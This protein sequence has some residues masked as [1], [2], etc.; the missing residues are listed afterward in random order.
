PGTV[1]YDDST[2]HL[3]E[4]FRAPGSAYFVAEQ[5]GRILGG[6]G[7][8]PT[9]GLPDGTCELV[10]MYLL[11]EARGTG[12]GSRLIQASLDFAA[13]AGYTQVYL[14]SMPELRNALSAYARFGF[15]Y[16]DAPLGNSGHHG[17]G[18]WMLREEPQ[19]KEQGTAE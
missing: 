1:Y 19:N 15:R 4:L 9:D 5:E 3:Y 16:L 11:P 6:G 7:I 8:Y 12:L 10:K 17:C 13:T 2:D 14:E 18:L